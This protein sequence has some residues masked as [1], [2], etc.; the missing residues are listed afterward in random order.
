MGP[1]SSISGELPIDSYFSSLGRT[2]GPSGS[3]E[4]RSL[5]RKNALDAVEGDAE[6]TSTKKH[7][8]KAPSKGSQTRP[9]SKT[10]HTRS[11]EFRASSASKTTSMPTPNSITKQ[12]LQPPV[13]VPVDGVAISVASPSPP[14]MALL[15]A[16]VT[17]HPSSKNTS[18]GFGLPTPQTVSHGSKTRSRADSASHLYS[19]TE[20][21]SVA[22]SGPPVRSPSPQTPT[23]PKPKIDSAPRNTPHSQRIVPSSQCFADEQISSLEDGRDPFLL[24]PAKELDRCSG[25]LASPL[26][27][28]LSP[29]PPSR[30]PTA[31]SS[32]LPFAS[33]FSNGCSSL[34]RSQSSQIEPTSQFEEIELRFS[35]DAQAAPPPVRSP[36]AMHD[37][38]AS[39]IKRLELELGPPKNPSPRSRD[40]VTQESSEDIHHTPPYPPLSP[41]TP[42]TPPSPRVPDIECEK[43]NASKSDGP[44]LQNVS[45]ETHE[46]PSMPLSPGPATDT[47]RG[48]PTPLSRLD[49]PVED[50][51]SDEDENFVVHPSP[52]RRRS[53]L[54]DR[55]PPTSCT[56]SAST[57]RHLRISHAKLR[58]LPSISVELNSD[59]EEMS[60]DTSV[61]A[62]PFS[63]GTSCPASSYLDLDGTLPS[64]VEDFLNMVDTNASSDT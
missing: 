51:T 14:Q 47:Q 43:V 34:H 45:D 32:S 38:N 29:Y 37:K 25:E 5:K 33:E 19:I 16:R 24:H 63:P 57:R 53:P 15:S 42:L 4:N 8:T 13:P 36:Q 61:D 35:S 55:S 62:F 40:N 2:A 10:G 1:R 50:P 46:I 49:V 52:V 9:E 54:Q 7:K 20:S 17:A 26:L 3:K 56:P 28:K 59:G 30:V 60:S 23:R 44:P 21:H 58:S 64:E 31:S 12:P 18:S 27:F 41:L 6:R 11:K 22:Q 48:K 39:S